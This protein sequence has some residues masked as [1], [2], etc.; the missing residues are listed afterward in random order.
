[1]DLWRAVEMS[2]NDALWLTSS[3]YIVEWLACLFRITACICSASLTIWWWMLRWLAVL[4]AISIIRVIQTVLPRLY[5]LRRTVR[6]SSSPN[7]RFHREKR[8]VYYWLLR[9]MFVCSINYMH[10][11]FN[12]NYLYLRERIWRYSTDALSWKYLTQVKT[13]Y[14]N[15]VTFSK[16]WVAVVDCD[17]YVSSK[18]LMLR[19]NCF[20]FSRRLFTVKWF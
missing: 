13:C 16:Q 19:F 6:S 18:L 5:R 1:M 15:F 2:S 9:Q 17:L 8:Y 4:H 3:L 14:W 7:E 10:S 12:Q 11:I 20:H